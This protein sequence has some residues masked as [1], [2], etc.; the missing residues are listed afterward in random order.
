MMQVSVRLSL[1]GNFTSVYTCAVAHGYTEWILAIRAVPLCR[2]TTLPAVKS[3]Q[4]S[5]YVTLR[6]IAANHKPLYIVSRS[7]VSKR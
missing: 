4:V 7:V 6:V 2:F 5:L 3:S 1:E